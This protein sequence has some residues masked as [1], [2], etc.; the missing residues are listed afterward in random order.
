MSGTDETIAVIGGTGALGSALAL[1]LARAHY[2]VVIGSRDAAKAAAA[3]RALN[4]AL[5][6]EAIA[7]ADNAS[8]AA[9]AAL[10]ILA[11]PYAAER[12]TVAEIRAALAGKLLI[13]ATA[14]LVPPR[15]GRVQ[16]PEGGSAVAAVQALLGKDVRVVSAFQ[17]VAAAKL[18]KAGATVEGD[19]LVCGD[20]EGARAR[21][22]ALAGAIGLRGVDAG[23]IC[24]SA[25]AEALTSVLIAINR[26]YKLPGSGIRIT[27]LEAVRRDQGA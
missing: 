20:D 21:V 7:S 12:A 4:G 26:R 17:T 23:P 16:L 5:G 10:V 22:I 19:V 18:K 13:D 3:A 6:A 27:G 15:V 11:V 24:N 9:E 2:R 8:A 1:R 25:A 14:P